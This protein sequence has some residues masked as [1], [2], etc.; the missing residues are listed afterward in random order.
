MRK[1]KNDDNVLYKS[2]HDSSQREHIPSD[3]ELASTFAYNRQNTRKK[4][5][6]KPYL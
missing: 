4:F 6:K 5:V 3:L 1:I 2:F